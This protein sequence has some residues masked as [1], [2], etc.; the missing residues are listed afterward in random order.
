LRFLV[1]KSREH[2]RPASVPLSQLLAIHS[3]AG[4]GRYEG[5]L[6]AGA[7]TN[8]DFRVPP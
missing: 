5:P 1:S 8:A 6:M 7:F 4:S 2:G 3:L